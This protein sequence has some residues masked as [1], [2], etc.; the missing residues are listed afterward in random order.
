M[1]QTPSSS[2]KSS[3]FELVFNILIPSLILMKLSSEEYLGPTTALI[4][5]LLFPLSYGLK[6][7]IV[8]KRFNF[9]S[10]LGFV[11]I[12]LTGG[13]GLLQLDTKWLALKEALIP[14]LIGIAIFVS[15][16]TRYPAIQKM[17]FNDTILNLELITER[18]Q[19]NKRT[20][21]FDKTLK[22]CNYLF[23]STFLFSSIMNYLLAIWIVTSPAGTPAFNEELGK[24]TLYSYPAIAIPSML[25]MMGIFYYLWVKIRTMTN[26]TTE[27]VFRTN[28]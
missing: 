27:Q 15:T 16:F 14:G 25:M 5:A 24:L 13:I 20:A 21:T 7:F 23:A 18:L 28:D 3:L 12:L 2:S 4:L 9:I 26:L 6:S 10:A 8:E 17:L 1:T 22:N 11:S 19:Q